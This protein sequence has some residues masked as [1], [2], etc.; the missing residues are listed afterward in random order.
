MS[1]RNVKEGVDL[2]L[3]WQ[4]LEMMAYVKSEMRFLDARR[5]GALPSQGA[6]DGSLMQAAGKERS[7]VKWHCIIVALEKVRSEQKKFGKKLFA[8]ERIKTTSG[9]VIRQLD[10]QNGRA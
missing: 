8:N 6:A 3:V 5:F 9:R 1:A 2:P 4:N 10:K 7:A